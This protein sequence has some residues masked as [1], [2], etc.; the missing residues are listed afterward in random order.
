MKE[1]MDCLTCIPQQLRKHIS[2]KPR[3][4]VQELKRMGKWLD[5]PQLVQLV[6]RLKVSSPVELRV[7]L[8]CAFQHDGHCHIA[9]IVMDVHSFSRVQHTLLQESTEAVLAGLEGGAPSL[10][11]QPSLPSSKATARAV[12]DALLATF[13]F[14]YMPP[15]RQATLITLQHPRH[16]NKCYDE[17][18]TRPGCKGN[19]LEAL[20]DGS[21]L[22]TIPH[23]KNLQR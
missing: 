11:L 12:H 6:V 18:C 8:G 23:H 21:Y 19:R 14:G 7:G 13:Q 22:F 20:P 9:C 3:P 10:L 17:A 16:V 2:P 1:T 15:L 5:A 4:T